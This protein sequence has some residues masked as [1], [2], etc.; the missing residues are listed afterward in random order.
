MTDK[1]NTVN[2]DNGNENNLNKF[3]TLTSVSKRGNKTKQD[4]INIHRKITKK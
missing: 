2:N 1:K 3:D 4:K